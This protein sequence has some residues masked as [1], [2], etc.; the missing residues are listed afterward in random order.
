MEEISIFSRSNSAVHLGH[1]GGVAFPLAGAGLPLPQALHLPRLQLG[2]VLLLH[3][4]PAKLGAKS[5]MGNILL[6]LDLAREGG[7]REGEVDRGRE[8]GREALK[9]RK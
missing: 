8:G 1:F 5:I 3:V 6:F 2:Q 4:H 7:G 9:S